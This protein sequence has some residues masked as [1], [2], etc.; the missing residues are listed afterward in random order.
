MEALETV[1][2]EIGGCF[3]SILLHSFYLCVSELVFKSEYAEKM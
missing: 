3:P 1:F 2:N